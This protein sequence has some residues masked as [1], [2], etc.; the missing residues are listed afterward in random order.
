MRGE[1]QLWRSLS[2]SPPELPPRARRI[3]CK[4]RAVISEIGTTS[5]CAENTTLLVVTSPPPRNYLRVRGEYQPPGHLRHLLLELPP[6]AR[7]IPNRFRCGFIAGGT[8]SA[9]A[10][11]TVRLRDKNHKGGNYLRVRGEYAISS[12]L[13]KPLMELPP[14][15]RRILRKDPM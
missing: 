12:G 1:Y 3:L 13:V 9:C 5:A 2:C 4:A 14:R 8:T 10:E 15:A 11:N 6:R 7:R